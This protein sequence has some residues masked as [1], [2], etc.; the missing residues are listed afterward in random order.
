MV[1]GDT[2]R[3]FEHCRRL[4]PFFS[5]G[6]SVEQQTFGSSPTV[7]SRGAYSGYGTHIRYVIAL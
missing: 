2:A 7:W 5:L 3:T 1:N 6:W 4:I